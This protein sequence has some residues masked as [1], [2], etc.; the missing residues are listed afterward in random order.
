MTKALSIILLISFTF[1]FNSCENPSTDLSGKWKLIDLDFGYSMS[2]LTE[3]SR[4]NQTKTKQN[5]L[6]NEIHMTFT[7]E[8]SYIH[9]YLENGV[10]E[11]IKGTYSIT[12]DAKEVT[13]VINDASETVYILKLTT[14]TLKIN[15]GVE[16]R[17]FTYTKVN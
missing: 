12:N 14:K 17:S 3:E 11:A 8:G 4:E 9:E 16:G 5:L 13:T 15:Y 1:L 7:K 2:D 6:N 10:K